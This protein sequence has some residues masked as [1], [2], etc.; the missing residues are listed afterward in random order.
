MKR[1]KTYP[2]VAVLCVNQLNH[3]MKYWAVFIKFW[4]CDR[5]AKMFIL[6]GYH[7]LIRR[8]TTSYTGVIPRSRSV[9]VPVVK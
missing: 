8:L 3:L 5:W 1:N 2:I 9:Y 4:L 6:N 7:T